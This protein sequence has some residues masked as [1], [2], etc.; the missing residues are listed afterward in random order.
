MNANQPVRRDLVMKA[1]GRL[2]AALAV[3]AA[4]LF[5]PAGTLS[6]WQAWVYLAIIFIPV[7][8]VLAYLIK[9]DPILL[10]RRLRM[11]ETEAQQKL[12][13]KLSYI[14][15]LIAFLL[16]GL[17]KRFGWS[18]VPIVV[19][20][21]ADVLVLSGYGLFVLVLRENRYASRIIEVERQQE[22]ITTGPYALVRHPMYLGVSLMYVLSPLALGSYWGMPPA[23]L[24]IV[25]LVARIRNEESV[26]LS[27]LKGYREYTEKTR[28]RLLPGVW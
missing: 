4:V 6:Y 10:E 8:I 1:L 5:L 15:F 18:S 26:L 19:V 13:I 28:Y 12:I 16:P 27:D 17:D 23:A 7:L 21:V 3:L 22:V 2:L 25:L 14:W 24:L 11:R 9:N 20:L